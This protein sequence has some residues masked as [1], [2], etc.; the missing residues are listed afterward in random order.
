MTKKKIIIISEYNIFNSIG[1]TEKYV[2]TLIKGL[3][4]SGFELIFI[5]QG[6]EHELISEIIHFEQYSYVTHFI[7]SVSFGTKEIKQEITSQTWQYIDPLL[8]SFNPD[9]VHIHTLS[10]FFNIRHI[11]KCVTYRLKLFLSLHVPGH[12]CLKGDLIKYNKIPCDGIIGNQCKLCQFSTGIKK[13]VSNILYN[14]SGKISQNIKL[15]DKLNVKVIC[16]SEWQKKQLILNGYSEKQAFVVRQMI[17][18]LEYSEIVDFAPKQFQTIGYLG[19]LSVEK[20]TKMLFELIKRLSND[21]RFKFVLGVPNSNSSIR[22]LNK[23][24]IFEENL[25]ENL[26]VRFDI[27]QSNKQDFFKSIDCL[28]IPSFVIETGPIVLLESLLY[29]RRVIAPRVGGPLE[30]FHEFGDDII[31]YDWNYA[32]SAFDCIKRLAFSEN[33]FHLS[34]NYGQVFSDSVNIF[35]EKHMLIYLHNDGK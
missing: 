6:K 32:D 10:T 2:D 33:Y 5:T 15:L 34:K 28:F 22:E 25:K 29:Q 9:Y 14:Y 18:P 17:D 12:L 24:K 31:L 27:N 8:K 1:G 13:G 3:C 7:P 19:R 20:G 23:L 21:G 11:E 26:T 4:E 30:F 16:T 35:I